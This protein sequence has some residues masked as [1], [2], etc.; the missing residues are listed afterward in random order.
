MNLRNFVNDCLWK[1][2]LD[3]HS[4]QTSD[5]LFLTILVSLR[6]FALLQPKIRAVNFQKYAKNCLTCY[7]LQLAKLAINK[8]QVSS[9]MFFR[10]AKQIIA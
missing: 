9:R 1:R 7:L 10:K 6:P 5:L 8:L 4:P 3:S 2:F